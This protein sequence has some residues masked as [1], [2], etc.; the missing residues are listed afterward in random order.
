M[1]VVKTRLDLILWSSVCLYKFYFYYF[2]YYLF[3][4]SPKPFYT[5]HILL[6]EGNPVMGSE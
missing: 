1:D 4:S 3:I 2:Y 5:L 6:G